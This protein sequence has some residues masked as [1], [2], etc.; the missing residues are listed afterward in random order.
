MDHN[1]YDEDDDTLMHS[2]LDRGLVVH[3]LHMVQMST[4]ECVHTQSLLASGLAL[5]CSEYDDDD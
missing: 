4:R 1:Y 3:T 5:V 2:R